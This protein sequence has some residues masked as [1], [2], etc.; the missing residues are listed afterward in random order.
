[1]TGGGLGELRF[2][3][4]VDLLQLFL[5]HRRDIVE[6]IQDLLNAR[7]KPVPYLQ[8]RPLL[9]RQ[10]EDC[11]FTPAAVSDDQSG[12]RG[13][14][15]RAH[16]AGGFRPR[17]VPGLFN[18]LID[19]AEMAI[20]GFH[21][22]QQT[23]WPGRN[24]RVRYA[25]TLFNLYLLRCL[26]LMS[27]RLW[28]AGSSGAGDRLAKLQRV[29][30]G[31]WAGAPADQPVIVRDARW[32]IPLAQSPTTD[33]LAAYF[34]VAERVAEAL[35]EEDGIEIQKAGVRMI[36]GHL[37]S[38]IRH[39]C[40][41]GGVSLDEESVVRRTRT[42]NALD[43]AL[44]IQGLVTIL[45]AYEHALE[46]GDEH[47][48]LESA[49]AICQG[50]SPDPDLFL[51]R[52]DLLSAYSMI[53][54]VFITTDRDREVVYT[55]MGL[56]HVRLLREYRALIGRLS[57]P[58]YDDCPRFR[59]VDGSYSPYG[60]IYGTASNLTEDMALKTLQSDVPTGF[61]LEDVFVDGGDDAGKL[62]WVSG[63]R[64]LAHVD[65]E[66]QRL[67]EYPQRFAEE[68]FE[69]IE[70][71]LAGRA[72]DSATNDV[73]RTGRLLVVPGA[74]LA[75][76][77][78]LAADSEVS[79]IPDLPLRYIGSSDRQIVAAHRADSCEQTRLLHDRQEGYFAVSHETSG[80][81]IAIRKDFLTEV[82]GAG[83]DARIV[84]L[85]PVAAGILRLMCPDLV[86]VEQAPRQASMPPSMVK[87]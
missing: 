46:S 26:E 33:E 25:H 48:R 49:S 82:L 78:D 47:G 62:A 54:H 11:F 8:N 17:R 30:D 86:V 41:K 23:R 51:N 85:A 81:W 42:S 31:L 22:W 43:F 64:K 69:R 38:Q 40:M 1:M 29:L 56:R 3:A 57:K 32:L 44:L 66:V 80:G 12:L 21:C 4:H 79:R 71:A 20:R 39:Y 15:D 10:F 70:H 9:S 67:Y 50:I 55:R 7:R 76:D 5:A 72:S 65:R 36:A 74:D 83:R 84:G 35:G 77:G 6:K 19:P 53:E 45:E 16:W 52:V 18:D 13:E 24:G 27:M 37:R 87:A 68:I 28:D 73:V 2:Q 61:S 75:G 63:W 34:E 14:L 59:P 58:L 60:A